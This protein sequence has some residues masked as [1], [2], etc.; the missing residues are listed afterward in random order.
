MDK[1]KK[2]QRPGGE[3]VQ[4]LQDGDKKGQGLSASGHSFRG[5]ICA[6]S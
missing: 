2:N 5:N 3:A 4:G 6:Q 1:G